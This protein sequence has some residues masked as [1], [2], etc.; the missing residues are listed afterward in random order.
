MP[1]H[2][3]PFLVNEEVLVYSLQDAQESS[4]TYNAGSL[5]ILPNLRIQGFSRIDGYVTDSFGVHPVVLQYDQGDLEI[6][7]APND[8][9]FVYS[10]DGQPV[11]HNGIM[12]TGKSLINMPDLD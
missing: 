9:E 10:S 3:E 1:Y 7:Y 8:S 6:V 12:V 11:K 4:F 2:L 5:E